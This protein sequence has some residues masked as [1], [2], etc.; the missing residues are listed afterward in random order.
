MIAFFLRTLKDK[1]K[2]LTIFCV[3]AVAFLEMYIATFPMLSKQAAQFNEMMKMF[4][5]EMF[6]SFGIDIAAL[7]FSRLESYLAME[8]YNIFWPILGIIL[9]ITL[10]SAV[11][12]ADVEKGV[13]ETYISLPI[14]R[15]K[16][17]LSRYLAGVAG[18]IIFSFTT[19]YAIIPL[20]MIHN[21]N[22][23]VANYS[24]LLVGGIFFI[25]AIFSIAT[26]ISVIS[27]EKGRV[28]MITGGLMMLMYVLNVLSTLKDSLVNLKYFSFFYYFSASSLL[29][30]N[31]YVDYSILVFSCVIIVF[32]SLSVLFFK[33]RDLSV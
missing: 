26:F 7:T 30:K 9:S 19:I 2:S 21:I 20:A 4:P 23:D 29:D 28:S 5:P 22:Y 16:I 33:K 3:G 18:V 31:Q 14:S 11:C 27:S 12:A 10:A 32:T 6:K 8:Q 24:K 15:I 17:F 13:M 25:V 1:R